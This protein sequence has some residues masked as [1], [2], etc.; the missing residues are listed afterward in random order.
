MYEDLYWTELV[1]CLANTLLE[2]VGLSNLPPHSCNNWMTLI[3]SQ[4][5]REQRPDGWCDT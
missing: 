2:L 1:E 5:L 3:E 4:K